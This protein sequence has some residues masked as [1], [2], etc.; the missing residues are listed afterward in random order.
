[1]ET[2]DIFTLPNEANLGQDDLNTLHQQVTHPK[3][4]EGPHIIE[5]DAP[6]NF[7]RTRKSRR[8]A[9]LAAVEMS[10]SCPTAEQAAKQKFPITF[11][12]DYAQSVLDSETGELLE[13]RQLIKHPKLQREWKFSCGNEIGRLAQE[14]PS[15]ASTL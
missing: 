8:E 10:G 7:R 13:Y 5:D 2:E 15:S 6:P 12:C 11:L 9:L 1:M 14:M 4:P 3:E